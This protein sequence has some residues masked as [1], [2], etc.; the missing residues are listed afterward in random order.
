MTMRVAFFNCPHCVDSFAFDCKKLLSLT[1]HSRVRVRCQ[2]VRTW[3]RWSRTGNHPLPAE[4]NKQ[5]PR[6][7][8]AQELARSRAQ[9]NARQKK[10]CLPKSGR[11]GMISRLGPARVRTTPTKEAGYFVEN[12]ASVPAAFILRCPLAP[13]A[14]ETL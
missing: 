4:P 1:L 13:T 10:G 3:S 5:K 7:C 11:I 6:S 14:R 2:V 8:R 12:K 9:K